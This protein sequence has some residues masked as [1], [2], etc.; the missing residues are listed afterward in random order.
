MK[1]ISKGVRQNIRS[2]NDNG[3]VVIKNLIPKK[4]IKNCLKDLDNFKNHSLAT[5]KKHVV[6]D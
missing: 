6:F 2:F 5:Q 1:K 3:F 4:L